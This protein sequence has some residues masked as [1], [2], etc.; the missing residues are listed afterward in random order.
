MLARTH[1]QTASPTTLGKEI[2][3]IVSRL[4]RASRQ[5]GAVQI[6]G[7]MNGAVGNYN[8]HF[9]A[10]P[11][12]DWDEQLT[13]YVGEDDGVIYMFT[14]SEWEMRTKRCGSRRF[15]S[16]YRRSRKRYSP[17]AVAA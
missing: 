8:A 9:A 11:G 14:I 1:G 13:F 6:M 15:S 3:N 10:Y 17:S 7:K 5:I 2:A 16:S 12:F 4:M